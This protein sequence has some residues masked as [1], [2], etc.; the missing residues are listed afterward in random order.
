MCVPK[1]KCGGFQAQTL[2]IPSPTTAKL[3]FLLP[4]GR[5]SF[6]TRRPFVF[7]GVFPE[8]FSSSLFL[9][10]QS[11][12]CEDTA[13]CLC[14]LVPP[15]LPLVVLFLFLWWLCRRLARAKRFCFGSLAFVV[16]EK[17]TQ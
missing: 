9:D 16:M 10:G 17:H 14:P 7:P 11:G 3:T 13:L 2:F 12:G 15:F 8:T 6:R 5:Q 4:D 1:P